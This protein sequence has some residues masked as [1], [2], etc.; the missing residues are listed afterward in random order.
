MA[1]AI[2]VDDDGG[3]ER[4]IS[5]LV[6]LQN[7]GLPRA[8]RRGA[9]KGGLVL[10]AATRRN[11]TAGSP[12]SSDPNKIT[13]RSGHMRNALAG[14]P[15]EKIQ[16]GSQVRVGY[17]E[18]LVGKYVAVHEKD[19]DT[20]IVPRRGKLLAIPLPSI[21]T[22]AG[23]P[24]YQSPRQL[25]GRWV[26]SKSSKPNVEAV[27]LPADGGPPAFVGVTEVTIHPRRPLMKAKDEVAP[28]ISNVIKLE[29][30]DAVDE[31]LR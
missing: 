7:E 29:I 21:M 9:E 13:G 17:L 20:K 12:G 19:T 31:A 23:V 8:K 28:K 18:G 22:G 14:Q 25:E 6:R 2:A 4:L 3:F 15:A 10:I 27:F 16:R 1:V 5:K 11:F 26:K 24:R 30:A